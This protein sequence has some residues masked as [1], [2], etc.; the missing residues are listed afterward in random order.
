MSELR[1]GSTART[2]LIDVTERVREAAAGRD[3]TLVTVFVPHTTAGVVVQAAGPGARAVAGD[4]AAALERLVDEDAPWEHIHE[5][6]RNP[7][8]HVRAALTASSVGIPLVGGELA[9]GEHQAIYL[10]EF[11]GPRER[12]LTVTVT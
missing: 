8:A 10:A 2:E 4:V 9:L 1:V 7:W 11:D 12:T 3:G 6:D 5:G